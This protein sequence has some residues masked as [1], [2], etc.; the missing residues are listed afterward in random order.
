MFLILDMSSVVRRLSISF[1]GIFHKVYLAYLREAFFV[2][3]IPLISGFSMTKINLS[4]ITEAAPIIQKYPGGAFIAFDVGYE[5]VSS[6]GYAYHSTVFG[7]RY[8]WRIYDKHSLSVLLSNSQFIMALPELL[9]VIVILVPW[10][11]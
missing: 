5:A 8:G 3:S 1:H 6:G 4:Q 9:Q 10:I 2:F 7:M 11:H